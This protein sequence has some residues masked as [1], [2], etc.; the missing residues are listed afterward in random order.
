M[1]STIFNTMASQPSSMPQPSLP[2]R[3]VIPK[4]TVSSN[5]R[6]SNKKP[7]NGFLEP[8]PVTPVD[9]LHTLSPTNNSERVGRWSDHEHEVF[10]EGL[11]KYGKQWKTIANM[12]GTRTVVQVRTH[13]QKYFQKV[14]KTKMEA[15]KLSAHQAPAKSAMAHY[16]HAQRPKSTSG[17]KRKSFASSSPGFRKSKQIK[18][19]LTSYTSSAAAAEAAAPLAVRKVSL[20][21]VSPSLEAIE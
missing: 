4:Q 19:T 10:L 13:A 8:V 6:P 9:R 18:S 3:L 7:S 14:E 1:T 12:I 2:P 16:N 5:T 11:H 21:S 15:P 17:S 20:G